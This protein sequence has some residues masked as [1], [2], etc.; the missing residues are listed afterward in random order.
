[1]PSTTEGALSTVSR[2]SSCE[3]PRLRNMRIGKD[4]LELA[5]G[6]LAF[7]RGEG[8]G[9]DAIGVGEANQHLR[10]D[11]ALVALHEVE[12]A[13]RDAELVRHARLGDLLLAPQPLEAGA[14]EEL[15]VDAVLSCHKIYNLTRL[16]SL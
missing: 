6:L 12:V 1:M 14:D 15:A 3:T 2:S 8:A 13:R 7:V 5:D 16:T 10:R 11:R 4:L 9:I